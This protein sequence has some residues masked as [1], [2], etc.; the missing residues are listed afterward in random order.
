MLWIS[1]DNAR[2]R[3]E[4]GEHKIQSWHVLSTSAERFGPQVSISM[5]TGWSTWGCNISDCSLEIAPCITIFHHFS[6][7]YTACLNATN[8]RTLGGEVHHD[9]LRGLRFPQRPKRFLL[10][11]VGDPDRLHRRWCLCLPALSPCMIATDNKCELEGWCKK[12]LKQSYISYIL[13][14]WCSIWCPCCCR[15][16]EPF[17]K[18]MMMLQVIQV[19]KHDRRFLVSE[20]SIFWAIVHLRLRFAGHWLALQA[21]IGL[22]QAHPPTTTKGT[23]LHIHFHTHAAPDMSRSIIDGYNMI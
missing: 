20:L 11:N 6:M 1:W 22:N 2:L 10:L 5:A 12:W 4:P 23:Y 17:K 14:N 21:A 8:D 13:L 9:E 18:N 7:F 16:L 3:L 19:I 15:W